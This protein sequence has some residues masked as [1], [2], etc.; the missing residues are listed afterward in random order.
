M[1]LFHLHILKISGPLYTQFSYLQGNQYGLLYLPIPITDTDRHFPYLQNRLSAKIAI[2]SPIRYVSVIGSYTAISSSI[3]LLCGWPAGQVD[4]DGN[5]L[6]GAKDQ[7]TIKQGAFLSENALMLFSAY[8]PS[9]R[10]ISSQ[11]KKTTPSPSH[12]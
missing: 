9:P 6:T 7:A 2:S 11:S 10:R 3:G 4:A 8:R 5:R 1:F 12:S